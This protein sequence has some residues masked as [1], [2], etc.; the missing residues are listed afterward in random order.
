MVPIVQ[1][2]SI[3]L[4]LA[5]NFVTVLVVRLEFA[6]TFVLIH[7]YFYYGFFSILALIASANLCV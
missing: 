3:V 6:V 7:K 4:T 1:S 2:V 5:A